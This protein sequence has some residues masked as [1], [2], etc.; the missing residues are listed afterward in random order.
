MEKSDLEQVSAVIQRYVDGTYNADIAL[1]KSVFH[2]DACMNGYLGDQL[3][4]GTPEPF[5]EDLASGPSMKEKGDP[6]DARITS[7][8]V[9]DR[10][11]SAVL[12]E[13]G[14]RG[15]FTFEDH[16]QLIFDEEKWQI[17]SKTFTTIA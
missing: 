15:S 17:I 6:Y 5:F 2:K 3:I 1:L 11:A 13:S 14:F 16:F 4:T 10:I 12:Y 9:T 7:L 8:S